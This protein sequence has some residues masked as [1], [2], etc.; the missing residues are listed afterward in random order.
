MTCAKCK[1]PHRTLL[2]REK[3]RKASN[4]LANL[5]LGDTERVI[6][7][8]RITVLGGQG[9]HTRAKAVIDTGS[10][11]TFVSKKLAN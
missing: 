2:H 1:K 7:T 3:E 10:A 11:H 5:Q 4:M 8:A 6:G 9:L